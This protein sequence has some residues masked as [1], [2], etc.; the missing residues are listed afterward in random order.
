MPIQYGGPGVTPSAST[1]QPF[2]VQLNG[3]STWLI[4]SGRWFLL[5]GKYTIVQQLDP[6]SGIWRGI[7]AGATSG[8][9]TVI[10][11]DGV[12]YRLANLT[13]CAVGALITNAGTGYTSAPAVTAS[14]GSSV[15]R[16]ILG[17]AVSTTVTITNGGTNYQYPPTLLFS[18]PPPGGNQA[19][20][21]CTLSAGVI[22]AV[23]VTNQ[24]AGYAT[25]PT[26]TVIAD[27]REGL[28]GVGGPGSG[29]VLTAALTGSGT[30]TGLVCLDP[31]LAA[32][33]SNTAALPTL[34]FT[35]GG[36]S[37]AAATIIMDLSITAFVLSTT[38]VGSGITAPTIISA[39]G[40]FPSTAAAY[41]NP[42]LQSAL[43][44]GR[45]ANIVAT[46]SGTGLTTGG[47]TYNDGG[48]YPGFPTVYVQ[49]TGPYGASAVAPVFL[50]PTMG[51]QTDI[52]LVGAT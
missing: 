41:T 35:G 5:L 17:G 50:T 13:G 14:S 16:A 12:N 40:G 49:S 3:G 25:P 34:S 29:A 1:S 27:P 15:W 51:P 38:T 9:R 21:Y 33:Y 32:T 26:I 18:P 31:G 47:A 19:D 24:G 36:G 52:T 42:T 23:T 46:I 30:V 2:N 22:N 28:N 4:P 39:Y 48:V 11:S 44:R 8:E 6:I 43:V 37:N 20:G 10:F 7:G 45:Q